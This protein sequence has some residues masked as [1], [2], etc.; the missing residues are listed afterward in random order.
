[1]RAGMSEARYDAVVLATGAAPARWLGSS[2]LQTAEGGFVLVDRS[3]TSLS[4]PEVRAF[5]DCATVKDAPHPRSGLF[6]VRQAEAFLANRPFT[7]QPHWLAIISCGRKYA[8]AARGA[9][10]AEGALV[11]R[12]KDWI[13]RRWIARF[14]TGSK[15]N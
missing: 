11:W 9:M 14:K 13:D 10:A 6:A 8:I 7:P 4:H 3:M 15:R 2:G 12:W 5:G 1:V